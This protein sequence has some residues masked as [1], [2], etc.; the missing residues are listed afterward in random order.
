M[1]RLQKG[2]KQMKKYTITPEQMK[3]AQNAGYT[4]LVIINGEYYELES[5]ENNDKN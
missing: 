4:V 5:E 1:D 3:E 2:N